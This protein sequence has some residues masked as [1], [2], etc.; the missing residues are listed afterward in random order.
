MDDAHDPE[1]A[2]L[3]DEELARH[4]EKLSYLK[5]R[6]ETLFSHKA[7]QQGHYGHAT[8]LAHAIERE[9][10]YIDW[11]HQSVAALPHLLA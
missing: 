2:R 1:V 11:L 3:F 5:T 7:E 8:L 10:Q 6:W 4:E 9:R